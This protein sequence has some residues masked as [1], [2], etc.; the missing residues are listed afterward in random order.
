MTQLQACNL[1]GI[2]DQIQ[3]PVFVANAQ[4]D[5]LFQG[6]GQVVASKLGNRSSFRD[7]RRRWLASTPG[8]VHSYA[9]PGDFYF[10]FRTF[11]T[12]GINLEVLYS[13]L[14]EW[15]NMSERMFSYKYVLLLQSIFGLNCSMP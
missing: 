4:D 12:K 2:V 10:G 1:Q 13:E 5:M 15:L 7:R 9:K 14:L 3:C 8:W 11:S 6:E